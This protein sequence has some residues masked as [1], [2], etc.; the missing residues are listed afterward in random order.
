MMGDFLSGIGSELS[1]RKVLASVLAALIAIGTWLLIAH[2]CR[3][4]P[5]PPTLGKQAFICT[6]C[7]QRSEIDTD[8]GFVKDKPAKCPLCGKETAWV[9]ADCPHCRQSFSYGL[10]CQQGTDRSA[11]K[12][13]ECGMRIL[14]MAKGKA[15]GR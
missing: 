8:M 5:H 14:G 7:N 13:P 11:W 12:C 2:A 1:E 15:R 3:S 4:S 6:S 9:R 10:L